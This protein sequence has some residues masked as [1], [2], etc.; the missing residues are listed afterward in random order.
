MHATDDAPHNISVVRR[1]LAA[2]ALFVLPSSSCLAYCVVP[3]CST[4]I[5]HVW[6]E[7]RPR[8][9]NATRR[10]VLLLSLRMLRPSG[11][12]ANFNAI[13]ACL[14]YIT[15]FSMCCYCLLSS[16]L[17]STL[18][19]LEVSLEEPITDSGN[20]TCRCDYMRIQRTRVVPKRGKFLTRNVGL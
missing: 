14:S 8:S 16:P 9:S 15:H 6:L 11:V 7:H 12:T 13:K 18:D 10:K 3:T 19:R 5:N 20:S 2:R 4:H 17:N 1:L